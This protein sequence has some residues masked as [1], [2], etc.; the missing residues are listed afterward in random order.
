MRKLVFLL[1]VVLFLILVGFFAIGLNTDPRLVPSPLIGKPAPAFSLP[2][3][4]DAQS[5]LGTTD[6]K[7]QVTLLNV[8]ATWCVSCR[9]EHD[10]LMRIAA[11]KQVK[12][13]GLDYKDNRED[14]LR[15]LAN[16]G[17]PYVASAFDEHGRIA[18]DWGVYGTPETF[19]IDAEGIVRYKHVGP[20]SWEFWQSSLLPMI[21][22]LRAGQG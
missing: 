19:L 15:W 9:A 11:S 13:Y 12:I 14:A 18:I 21:E 4:A 5:S 16:L 7:G 10:V 2:R 22:Q 8:W 17:D 3:L 6:F 20:L 1:P